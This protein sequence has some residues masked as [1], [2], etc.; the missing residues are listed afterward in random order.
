MRYLPIPYSIYYVLNINGKDYM[1]VVVVLTLTLNIYNSMK[2]SLTSQLLCP[3][4]TSLN[5]E[6]L[7]NYIQ[8]EWA[9]ESLCPVSVREVIFPMY[10]GWINRETWS[11]ERNRSSEK[12]H[13][14][15]NMWLYWLRERQR[16]T[17][18]IAVSVQPTMPVS[19]SNSHTASYMSHLWDAPKS[20]Q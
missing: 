5:W 10:T 12:S 9:L 19:S 13:S 15:K 17:E 4:K 20:L 14:E 11:S 7:R 3:L 18:K 2:M 8:R 16:E 1:L 6:T